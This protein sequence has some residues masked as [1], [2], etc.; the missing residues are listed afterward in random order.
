MST[1]RHPAVAHY[2]SQ[3]GTVQVRMQEPCSMD[4]HEIEHLVSEERSS[5]IPPVTPDHLDTKGVNDS[6]N[7]YVN[8]IKKHSQLN[9]NAMNGHVHITENPQFYA[10]ECNGNMAKNKSEPL[11][12]HYEEDSNS[13]VKPSKFYDFYKIFDSPKKPKES[14][15]H[16]PYSSKSNGSIQDDS[17][18]STQLTFLNDSI[19]SQRRLSPV[20]EPNG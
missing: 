18:N 14:Q 17:L 19:N 16:S 4:E 10:F 5:H 15:H 2:T 3:L 12:R 8:G 20:L 11:L 7:G 9:G 1:N 13:N 6:P